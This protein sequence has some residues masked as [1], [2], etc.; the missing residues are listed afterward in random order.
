MVRPVAAAR[1]RVA[2]WWR[3]RPLG[4]VF[5][6]YLAS[7]LVIATAG[8]AAVLSVVDARQSV[9]YT[10]EIEAGDGTL[11]RASIETGPYIY[12]ARRDELVPA[13]EINLPGD[14]PYAVFVGVQRDIEPE[15]E[16][17]ESYGESPDER[18]P[19]ADATMGLVRA[20]T[21]H[22]YDWG[23]NYNYEPGF[24]SEDVLDDRGVIAPDRL[25][26]Y[27]SANR[28]GR[29]DAVALFEQAT[30]VDL[31]QAFG[32]DMVSNVAYYA[33]GIPADAAP[34]ALG[35]LL[36][37]AAPFVFYGGLAW[38]MFRRFYR[39]HIAGP[40][41]SL[42]GAAQRIA[43]QDLDFAIEP[44]RGRELGS[45]AC[46]LEDMRASLLDAQREL[47]R[48][49]EERRRL[50]AA[51]AHDLRTPVTVLKGTVE[52]ARLRANR[53][54]RIDEATLEVLA[55][56][57]ARLEAY[58][59]AMGG[60][61][62]L[63]DRAIV[64]EA[65]DAAEACGRIESAARDVAM[66]RRPGLE[67]SCSRQLEDM[68]ELA[69]DMPLVEEVL[70]NIVS[71]ACVPAASRVHVGLRVYTESPG[72]ALCLSIVVD[73]DGPG[74]TPEALRRG[75]DPFFSENKSA[76]HFGLGLN[77]SSTLAR[78]HGGAIELANGSQGGARVCAVF[79]AGGSVEPAGDAVKT[80]AS[81]G[82]SQRNPSR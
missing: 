27:D 17:I 10:V 12:D 19:E 24:T 74:F 76:E 55:S 39:L 52:M 33:D 14:N 40:L 48:T 75:C 69:L 26:A 70:G 29:V 1:E 25:P 77:I 15:R 31:R 35:M 7:Y 36:N 57:V 38:I 3:A 82:K 59:T 51:F 80:A 6:A 5:V 54:E 63:E 68:G 43:R 71:N 72:A 50:N 46:T 21:V 9:Y 45:L 11:T 60:L 4:T 32:P 56:Q 18:Y 20:G 34:Y 23:L 30:G 78:L 13:T 41:G 62:K 16:P 73:D 65:V 49:A 81:P 47:W 58:A 37:L 42:A 61:S 22:L 44:V 28:A 53:G 66:A 79:D 64:R 8:T 67:V 2:R